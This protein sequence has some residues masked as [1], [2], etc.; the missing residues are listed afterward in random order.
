M[1]AVMMMMMRRANCRADDVWNTRLA[2]E[3]VLIIKDGASLY[4]KLLVLC[5]VYCH[6]ME[7]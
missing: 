2:K 1:I 7:K 6:N 5:Q 4:Q 3:Q